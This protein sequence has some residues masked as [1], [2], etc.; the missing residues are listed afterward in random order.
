[1]NLNIIENY[2][3]PSKFG[4]Y[5]IVETEDEAT[6]LVISKDALT[7]IGNRI[8]ELES[9]NE[10]LESAINAKNNEIALLTR[11]KYARNKNDNVSK[12]EIDSLKEQNSIIKSENEKLKLQ[13]ESLLRINRQRTNKERNLKPR[14]NHSG[15]SLVYSNPI[16]KVF[17]INGNNKQAQFFETIFITPYAITIPFE[18][19]NSLIERDLIASIN[20]DGTILNSLGC[21]LYCPESDYTKII[22]KKIPDEQNKYYNQLIEEYEDNG[23]NYCDHTKREELRKKS[24][25]YI[26]NVFFNKKIRMNGKQGYWEVV[27]YH[28]KPCYI[29]ELIIQKRT[30]K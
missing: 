4:G 25:E 15:Y 1:M 14:K 7:K 29:N 27:L 17:R 5:R 18:E 10:E 24:K 21:E 23:K 22:D 2:V 6:A 26:P 12:T 11:E 13:N 30:S 19:A 20:D 16:E 3:V 9:L 8:I 28:L